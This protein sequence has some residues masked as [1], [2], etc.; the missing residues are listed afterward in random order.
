MSQG[1]SPQQLVGRD[2]FL[3]FVSDDDTL[4][5]LQSVLVELGWRTD[6]CKKGGLR[7]AVQALSVTASPAML[8]IDLSDSA[9]PLLDIESLA[10]VCEPGTIVFAI[11]RVNDVAFYRDLLARG[12]QDYLVK[13]V[14]PTQLRDALERARTANNAAREK[15]G[16]SENSHVSTAI[17]GTR[18]GVGAS[19]IATS[20]AWLLS[21]EHKRSTALLDLDVHF[22]TAALTLDLEPGRGLTDAIENPGRI[23]GLF[24]ERAM[25]RA[26]DK[27]SIM[28]AEAPINSALITD[29]SAFVRLEQEFRQSF[30]A[31]IIDLPRSMM[32]NF[33]QL[34]AGV[35]NVV[36]ATEMTLSSA[37]DAIRILS[38]LRM[39]A[40]E[41]QI[42][43]AANKVE[44]GTSEISQADF[45]AA[46]EREVDHS[47][48][49]DHKAAVNAA[50]LGQS[51]AEANRASK[52]A[53]PLFKLAQAIVEPGS[54][55]STQADAEPATGSLL[56]KID[57]KG[58]LSRKDKPSAKQARAA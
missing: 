55:G 3:A 44:A 5:V 7:V 57:W 34:V 6:A 31:C 12:I 20:L 41:A 30:E 54:E 47:I 18:G 19:M 35:H 46:I 13:P 50:R 32:V 25:I 16:E 15:G 8:L 14:S 42:I 38:W 10:E 53:A 28:S 24:I 37:R 56:G 40:P 48:P 43:L 4:D 21:T 2:P 11:G 39:N 17:I 52:T 1:T 23:D 49:Y 22:G 9:D 36:L 29:G 45:T 58:L 26:G 51:F 27:L 33:P